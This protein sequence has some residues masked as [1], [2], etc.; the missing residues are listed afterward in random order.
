MKADLIRIGNSQGIRIPKPL[1]EHC[2][3]KGRVEI[4]VKEGTLVISPVP[5]VREGW[6]AAFSK[7]AEAGD[8][9][10]LVPDDAGHGWDEVEWEW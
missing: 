4:E 1:I 5:T 2:G 3:L 7:M 9:R 8:D 10:L 6:E